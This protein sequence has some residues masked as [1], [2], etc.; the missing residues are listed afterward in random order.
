MTEA[1]LERAIQF[2]VDAIARWDFDRAERTLVVVFSLAAE[3][4]K[5]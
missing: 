3:I 1:M 5:T 2:A 4:V